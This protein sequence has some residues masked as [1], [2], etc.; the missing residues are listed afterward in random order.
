VVLGRLEHAKDDDR[1]PMQPP[2]VL[3][4]VCKVLGRNDVLISD[5]G[6][7]KLWIGRMFPPTNRTPC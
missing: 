5:V 7:H 2:R 4:E 3:Y 1:L 6:L